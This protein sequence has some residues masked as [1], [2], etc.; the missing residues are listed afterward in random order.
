MRVIP[1]LNQKG[2]A[3]KSTTV[4]SL[5]AIAAEN[6]R[7][8]VVDIDPQGTAADWSARAEAN[9]QTHAFEVVSESDPE[10]LS[11]VRE[12]DFDMVF[13]D[14]PGNIENVELLKAIMSHADFAIMPT[15]PAPAAMKP[16][17]NTYRAAVAPYG[18][19]YRVVITRADS[20]APADVTDAQELLTNAGLKVAKS[21][22]RSYKDH[23]RAPGTGVVVGS[24]DRTRSAQKAES[25]YRTV[26]LELFS[27]WANATAPLKKGA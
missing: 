14:T 3:G 1:V 23:E 19:D 21:F 4:M 26:A 20:R 12:A 2:G 13:V 24:Y 6:S 27:V 9:G 5:A 25:D 8:L 18:V 16:L 11:R 10:I 22:V 7:V 17:M 15:E